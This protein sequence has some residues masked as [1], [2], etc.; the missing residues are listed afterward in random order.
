MTFGGDLGGG[1]AK[2]TPSSSSQNGS[3]KRLMSL[4]GSS[5]TQS[6]RVMTGRE[7]ASWWWTGR[8]GAAALGKGGVLISALAGATFDEGLGAVPPPP[9]PAFSHSRCNARKLA[10]ERSYCV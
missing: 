3:V 10:L 9:H 5:S 1:L 7:L 8:F 2:V 6:S 4:S